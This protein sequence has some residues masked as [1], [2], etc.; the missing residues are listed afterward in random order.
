MSFNEIVIMIV[1]AM[2]LGIAITSMI[3]MKKKGVKCIGCPHCTNH[4]KEQSVAVS[5]IGIRRKVA[6]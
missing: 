1:I 5:T 2:I 3:K 6:Q 4:C